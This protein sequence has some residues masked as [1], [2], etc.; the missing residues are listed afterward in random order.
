MWSVCVAFSLNAIVISSTEEE[1][2]W[3]T[4]F[5]S[6]GVCVCVC[7]LSLLW[8]V[9]FNFPNFSLTMKHM[10]RNEHMCSIKKQ[11][12]RVNKHSFWVALAL[13]WPGHDQSIDRQIDRV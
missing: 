9:D 12:D 4:P 6:S 7:V 5:G 10:R 1:K 11:T 2:D 8:L 3:K 13:A